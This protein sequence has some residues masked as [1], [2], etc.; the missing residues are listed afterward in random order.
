MDRTRTPSPILQNVPEEMR[1]TS[2]EEDNEPR[3]ELPSTSDE[4][5]DINVMLERLRAQRRQ[6]D[7]LDR[8]RARRLNDEQMAR[9]RYAQPVLPENELDQIDSDDSSEE[10]FQRVYDSAT[11]SEWL[12][13]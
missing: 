10:N 7:R 3:P 5:E 4:D 9:A 2:P 12:G 1:P 11:T 13:L 6:Q 8:I